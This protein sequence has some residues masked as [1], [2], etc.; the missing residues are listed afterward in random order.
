MYVCMYVC[1]YMYSY[2]DLIQRLPCISWISVMFNHQMNKL[3]DKM[4]F[5]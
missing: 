2:Q 3:F 4:Y 5:L 1:V